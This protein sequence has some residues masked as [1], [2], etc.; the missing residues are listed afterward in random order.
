[1]RFKTELIYID[2]EDD[3]KNVSYVT[4]VEANDRDGAIALA[5]IKQLKERPD[6]RS[7]DRWAWSVY[8]SYEGAT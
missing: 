4:F 7:T 6:L 3:S 2:Q 5:K 1:M 8:E